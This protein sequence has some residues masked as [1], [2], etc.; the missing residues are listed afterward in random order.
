ME[1]LKAEEASKITPLRKG[2]E[3]KLSAMLKQLQPG[4]AL[5]IMP[6]DIVNK[7]A[8]YKTINNVAKRRNWK[9][10]SGFLP[11]GSGWFARRLPETTYA[12]TDTYPSPQGNASAS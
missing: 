2:R 12:P 5:K 9:M 8:M 7:K 3:S 11:D 1:I 4:E 10:D 6:V